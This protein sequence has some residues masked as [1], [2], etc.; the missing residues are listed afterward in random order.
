MQKLANSLKLRY[1]LAGC[2]NTLFGY[3]AGLAFYYIF[4]GHKHIVAVGII[5]NILAITM[6]F[7]TYKLFVFR[8]KGNWF[9]EY[10]RSYVVYGVTAI[11]GVI[12]LWALVDK[13]GMPFWSAQGLIIVSTIIISYLCHS[14]FTFSC[15]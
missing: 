15:K 6:S 9:A 10:M 14:K 2:W 7:T 8:T 12:F 11:I 1:I 4:C 5:A 13:I 3:A